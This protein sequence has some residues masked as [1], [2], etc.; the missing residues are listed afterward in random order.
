[1]ATRGGTSH[2]SGAAHGDPRPT[3][4][5]LT[6]KVACS[7][8]TTRSHSC[9]SRKPPANATPL[10]A[11]IVGFA[12][13]MLRPNCG[14]KSFG[15]TLSAFCAISFKSPPAQN[16]LSPTP[17]RTSTFAASSSLKRRTASKSPVRTAL[18]SA[19]RASGRL[20]VSQATLSTT[21]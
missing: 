13:S 8:A 7:A 14:A 11:A 17:V 18:F 5:S 2:D 15:G 19:L 4:T 1:M 20:I 21:S 6:A 12:T 3:L 16:A 10:T 9:A